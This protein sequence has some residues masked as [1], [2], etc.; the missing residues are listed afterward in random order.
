MARNGAQQ[1]RAGAEG[2]GAPGVGRSAAGIVRW[3]HTT[4]T[5]N[6]RIGCWALVGLE[7]AA[8]GGPRPRAAPSRAPRARGGGAEL[9]EPPALAWFRPEELRAQRGARARRQRL[10]SPS[11]SSKRAPWLR[12]GPG[13]GGPIQCAVASPVLLSCLA[14]SVSRLCVRALITCRFGA[15]SDV[16]W[17]GSSAQLTLSA[18]GR[19]AGR[20]PAKHGPAYYRRAAHR[21]SKR[22]LG[23]AHLALLTS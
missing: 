9:A 19:M 5:T 14:C 21:I 11:E 10:T 3:R 18:H 4:Y 12:T 22:L 17:Q 16:A 7:T 20:R 8:S 1:R 15:A 6:I 23:P 2:A 13:A